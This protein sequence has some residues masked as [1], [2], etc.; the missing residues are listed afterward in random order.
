M[1]NGRMLNLKAS[2]LGQCIAQLKQRDVRVLRYQFLEEADMGSQLARS[3]GATLYGRSGPA[4]PLNLV[5]PTR[6]CC[7]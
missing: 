4:S 2:C 7:W 1:S 6:A 3:L 5:S